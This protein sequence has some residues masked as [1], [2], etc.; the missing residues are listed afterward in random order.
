M[1][2]QMQQNLETKKFCQLESDFSE[3][4][5]MQEEGYEMS[6]LIQKFENISKNNISKNIIKAFF[7]YLLDT[8]ENDLLTD[9]AQKGMQPN[10]A[11]KMAKNYVK[12]YS[13]NNNS[14]HKLIQH[15]KY[16]KAFE[17]YLTFEA[18]KWLQESKVLQK[19]THL[20]YID[21]LKLCCSNPDYSNHIVTYKKNKKSQFR[22]D[23]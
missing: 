16:G 13:Y 7:A 12:S 5:Q 21:F 14:L 3:S 1:S 4:S 19:E 15:D 8:K 6:D 9:F 2:N 18:E 11:R 10:Q 20:I 23:E 22:V 17:F